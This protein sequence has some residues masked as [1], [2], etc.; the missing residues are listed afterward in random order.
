M[1]LTLLPKPIGGTVHAI[2][3]KSHAHRLLISSALCDRETRILC[4]DT[5]DDID[6]TAGCLNALCARVQRVGQV[7]FW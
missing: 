4:P 7:G 2:S 5:S 3:S 6:A 1:K